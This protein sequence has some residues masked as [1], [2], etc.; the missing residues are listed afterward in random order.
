MV[1][2]RPIKPVSAGVAALACLLALAAAGSFAAR[3]RAEPLFANSAA[4]AD[5]TTAYE[6]AE[7]HGDM[8]LHYIAMPGNKNFGQEWVD[9]HFVEIEDATVR[10]NATPTAGRPYMIITG[11]V[12]SSYAGSNAGLT[13][14]GVFSLRPGAPS[15][16]SWSNLDVVLNA[17]FS[18]MY[19]QS[20]GRKSSSCAIA[21]NG[22][23]GIGG[24]PFPAGPDELGFARRVTQTCDYVSGCKDLPPVI[25]DTPT[26]VSHLTVD[27]QLNQPDPLFA[28]NGDPIFY[29]MLDAMTQD[30]IDETR[31]L[32]SH[33]NGVILIPD[34]LWQHSKDF[35]VKVTVK[36]RDSALVATGDASSP[37]G[38][39]KNVPI[40]L[41][42]AGRKLLLGR[43]LSAPAPFTLSV[44][45][46][47]P[48][49]TRTQR[50]TVTVSL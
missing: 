10:P 7:L 1:R 22:G 5:G 18:G 43:T 44:S 28:D 20:S 17:P 36:Y 35:Q 42:P 39:I 40:G 34:P 47:G 23:V 6:V 21:P 38:V 8:N 12:Q 26:N 33:G 31:P 9:L 41:T 50:S 13:C 48:G 4:A 49:G 16:I 30:L 27:P 29:W 25:V 45:I 2:L 19:V 3:A 14:S 11:Y 15:P 32:R 37:N 24:D 46:R